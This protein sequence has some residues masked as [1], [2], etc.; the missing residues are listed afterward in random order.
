M[1]LEE[2]VKVCDLFDTYGSFLSKQ[3]KFVINEH[4][5]LDRSLTEIAENQKISRQAVLDAISKSV[6]KLNEFESKLHLLEIKKSISKLEGT[7]KDQEIL[8][9]IKKKL[10]GG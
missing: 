6:K 7:L 3:Q 2:S 4:F 5:Y 1:E 8:D 9:Q 10:W